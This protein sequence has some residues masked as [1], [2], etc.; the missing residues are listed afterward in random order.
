MALGFHRT[1]WSNGTSGPQRLVEHLMRGFCHI[2]LR[3]ASEYKEWNSPQACKPILLKKAHFLPL[4]AWNTGVAPILVSHERSIGDPAT[5]N[6]EARCLFLPIGT[7]AR[8]S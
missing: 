7:T 6:H 5:G 4:I 3:P 8:A 1:Q 2:I